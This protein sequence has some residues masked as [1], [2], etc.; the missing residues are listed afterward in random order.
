MATNSANP[1]VPR[2]NILPLT[3]LATL[4][5]G[6]LGA[7]F[8][9][10]LLRS[11]RAT[12]TDGS[13]AA[14]YQDAFSREFLWLA[15]ARS[16][17]N[18][19][20]LAVFRQAPQGVLAGGD[21]WLFTVEEFAH[22]ADPEETRRLWIQAITDVHARLAEHG[23]PL[24]IALVPAK[25]A[26]LPAVSPP[27]PRAGVE[28][29]EATLVDLAELGIAAVDLRAILASE[30][31]WLRTDTHWTPEGA[32]QAAELI[33]ADMLELA[34]EMISDR[35]YEVDATETITFDGDLYQ[36]L[37]LGPFAEVLGPAP[38]VI[39]VSSIVSAGNQGGSL[40]DDVT[41]DAVLVGT[42]YSAGTAW[43]L[44]DRL[45]LALGIDLLDVSESGRG[46]LAPMHDYLAGDAL[47]N[48][49]PALVVWEV[50]ERYLTDDGF[51]RG[52]A[53]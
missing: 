30:S 6:L 5:A 9:P 34:P 45:R 19:L 49:P 51:L 10:A 11:P 44:A 29:Y 27:L 28:R 43:N 46:P 12:V 32:G 13:W 2:R 33:A 38:D 8:N 16:L 26:S 24:L 42:S 53:E 15:S 21:G 18:A 39:T 1:N 48:A 41:I 47:L 40:F 23:I 14:E 20:D 37:A 36:L 7:V 50:P 4:L 17:W 35:T 31:A 25:A 22:T 3:L 52:V